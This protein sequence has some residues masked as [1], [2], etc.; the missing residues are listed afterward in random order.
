M[1]ARLFRAGYPRLEEFSRYIDPKASSGFWRR[2][3]A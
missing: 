1:P 3:T 2:V